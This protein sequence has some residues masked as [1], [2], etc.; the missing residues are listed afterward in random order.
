MIAMELCSKAAT[1][2]HVRIVE[3]KNANS[4]LQYCR[5]VIEVGT[6]ES[7]ICVQIELG[8]KNLI[9]NRIFSTQGILIIKVNNYK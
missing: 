3:L 4:T 6:Y 9:S 1:L 2:Q 7:A 5:H 8:I